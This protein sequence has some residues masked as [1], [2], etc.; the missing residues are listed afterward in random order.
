VA[1]GIICPTNEERRKRK[2]KELDVINPEIG[3]KAAGSVLKKR[4][5][6]LKG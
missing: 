4:M 1:W 6:L 2:R 5:L 3:A